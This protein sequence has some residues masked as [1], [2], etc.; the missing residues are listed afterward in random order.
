MTVVLRDAS[1][2]AVRPSR[3]G[4]RRYGDS[5][6]GDLAVVERWLAA[7]DDEDPALL[8]AL[9]SEQVEII[10]PRGQGLMDRSVLS[11][12]LAR[13]GFRSR[14]LRWFCGADGRVV[15]EHLGQ[16]HDVATGDVQGERVIGSEFV[17]R[18]GRVARYVRHDSGVAD[19]LVAAGLDEHDSLVTRR[20]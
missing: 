8:E 17:V 10:G 2:V 4:G 19:A 1:C 12:W 9:S 7:V 3:R 6:I 16:W 18:D 20:R 15:V 13:A 11:E 14:P 5:V